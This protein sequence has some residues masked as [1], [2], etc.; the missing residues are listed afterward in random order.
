MWRQAICNNI[1][2]WKEGQG[3]NNLNILWKYWVILELVCQTQLLQW[4]HFLDFPDVL[5]LYETYGLH[6]DTNGDDMEE[7]LNPAY[8]LKLLQIVKVCVC[9]PKKFNVLKC[10][11]DDVGADKKVPFG[12]YFNS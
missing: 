2:K 1:L 9:E 6:L 10:V 12:L 11:T 3:W 4:I 8:D 7:N 5:W